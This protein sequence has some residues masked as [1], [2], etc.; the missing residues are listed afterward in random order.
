MD[1]TI[2]FELWK[3]RN[4]STSGFAS[5]NFGRGEPKRKYPA[6]AEAPNEYTSYRLY[7]SDDLINE[8][9]T[10]GKETLKGLMPYKT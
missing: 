4:R 5:L 3:S 10:I 2:F 1:K 6:N 8:I 7:V 9:V